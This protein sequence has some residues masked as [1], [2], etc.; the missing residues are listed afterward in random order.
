MARKN[1]RPR[2]KIGNRY[3]H[4]IHKRGVPTVG[5]AKTNPASMH[6]DVGSIPD[7]AQ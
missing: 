5:A 4:E 7:L 1:N 3:K 2:E 6:E